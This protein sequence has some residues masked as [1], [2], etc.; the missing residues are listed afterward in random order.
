MQKLTME[1]VVEKYNLTEEEIKEISKQVY[2]DLIEGK[3]QKE[4]PV[5][6]LIAGQPGAGK[7]GLANYTKTVFPDAVMLD[8]DEFR[9]Y[10]P[11]IKEILELYPE[12]FAA[13]TNKFISKVSGY[14]TD[15]LIEG[16]YDV[17]AHK[18]FKNIVIIDDTIIP[19]KNAGY[20]VHINAYAVNGVV[21]KLSAA[22]RT[23]E[24]RKKFGYNRVISNQFHD[25][26]YNNM[27]SII[28][29]AVERGLVDSV[30]V[31]MRGEVENEPIIVY[32]Q[33]SH[34]VFSDIVLHNFYNEDVKNVRTAINIGRT[35]DFEKTKPSMLERINAVKLAAVY[36]DEKKVI[37][38]IQGEYFTHGA[39]YKIPA[40]KILDTHKKGV[41]KVPDG[42][43]FSL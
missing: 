20:Q 42:A 43:N 29:S 8:I 4:N 19:M 16:R 22:E 11:K 38:I 12:F 32:M 17:I 24:E 31:F 6:I 26:A 41:I 27:I 30:Q 40:T 18:T 14:V 34:E 25:D 33:N 39:N 37:D 5:G 7:T 15:M 13:T 35:I 2:L 21:S 36:D 28:E 3:P 10:H 9:F 23:Q 1:Q